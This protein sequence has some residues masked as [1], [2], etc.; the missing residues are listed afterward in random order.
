MTT[1]L[2]A[3][4]AAIPSSVRR[5]RGYYDNRHGLGLAN[6]QVCPVEVA[7][8]GQDSVAGLGELELMMDFVQ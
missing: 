8:P 4:T 5:V 7:R 1:W 3:V 2:A 6:L